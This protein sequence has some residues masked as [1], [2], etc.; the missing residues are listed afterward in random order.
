MVLGIIGLSTGSWALVEGA[1][2]IAKYFN[3]SDM[4]IGATAV[5]LGTSLPE[6]VTSLRAA[7]EKEFDLLLG[8]IFGS[9]IINIVLVFGVSLVLNNSIPNTR[10]FSLDLGVLLL[11]TMLLISNAL[12]INLH[13]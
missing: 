10:D 1:T 5:A 9:N 6:L 7:K 12:K 13:L 8:N 11:L 4:I 3:I 2:G